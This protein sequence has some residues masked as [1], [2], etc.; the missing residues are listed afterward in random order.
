MKYHFQD[1]HFETNQCLEFEKDQ[2][3]F[4]IS[5]PVGGQWK[6]TCLNSAVVRLARV[7]QIIVT[8]MVAPILLLSSATL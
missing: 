7:P 6:I 2:V 1:A 8:V 5:R 4:K 3:E